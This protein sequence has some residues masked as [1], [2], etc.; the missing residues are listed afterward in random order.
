MQDRGVKTVD[1]P[2]FPGYL[3]CR[4]DIRERLLPVLTTPGVI[5]IVGAG[6]TPIAIGDDEIAAVQAVIRSGLPTIPWPSL[7]PG[8]R[9]FIERGPLAG[10]EGVAVNV[11]KKYRLIVSVSLLQRSLA[12]EIE[13]EWVRPIL[14]GAGANAVPQAE[15]L[16]GSARV[17]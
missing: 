16:R 14:N 17:A 7:A 15:R 8:S 9:V 5:R 3:F 4:L 10:L 12:V 6:K 11:E 2:L 1:L 13:R